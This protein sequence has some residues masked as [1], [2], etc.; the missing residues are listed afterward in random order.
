MS[1]S[2]SIVI[3]TWNKR[4]DVIN[5]LDSLQTIDTPNVSIIVVDNASTDGSVEAIR[6]HSLTVTLLENSENLGGTGGFNTGIR[7]ALNKFEQKYIWL[8]DN[9]AEV[10]PDTLEK[11]IAVM[12]VD[13]SIGIAGSCILNPE[14]RTQ[15]V[16]AGGYL[17][18]RTATWKPNLRY[19]PYSNYKGSPPIDVDYVPAC[20]ALVRKKLFDVSGMLDERFFLHWDDVDLGKVAREKGFRVVAVLDSTVFHGTEKGYSN[21]VL[22]YDVRNSL[23]FITKHFSIFQRIL[24]M[25]RVCFRSLMAARLFGSLG[26]LL[27]SWYLYQAVEN[28]VSG[29]FGAA[30]LPPSH[31]NNSVEADTLSLDAISTFKNVV[32]FAVGSSYEI[33]STVRLIHSVAPS[34]S[35]TLAAPLDRI[36]SYRSCALISHFISYDLAREGIGRMAAVG[37]KLLRSQYDCAISAGSGFVVPFAFFVPRHFVSTDNGSRIIVSKACL[38]SLWKLPF[39]ALLVLTNSVLVTT[40]CWLA[41]RR[42]P[43]Q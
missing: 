20:S 11:L 19:Q 24:P 43:A 31:V 17:D 22:Y 40:K 21:A 32:V 7:Y 16:E 4:T 15:I 14:D 1:P 2:V 39:L 26:E 5:L 25:F 34:A 10:K 3:V 30:P 8:L 37:V 6:N 36:D 35:V 41:S 13:A 27:L 29:R 18:Q 42:T 33:I 23:L 12:E 38:G 28:Y 9:D